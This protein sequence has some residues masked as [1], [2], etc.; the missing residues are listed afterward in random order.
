[1]YTFCTLPQ[2]SFGSPFSLSIPLPFKPPHYA[3][4]TSW[5]VTQH[6]LSPLELSLSA[7]CPVHL[8]RASTHETPTTCRTRLSGNT[9]LPCCG[10]SKCHQP[11][12]GRFPVPQLLPVSL[13]GGRRGSFSHANSLILQGQTQF[14]NPV[15][16]TP[17]SPWDSEVLLQFRCPSFR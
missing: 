3:V 2:L 11:S 7:G 12:P 8:Q 15:P 10:P 13:C 1:M 16:L 5:P 14:P 17:S 4:S 9:W 6:S